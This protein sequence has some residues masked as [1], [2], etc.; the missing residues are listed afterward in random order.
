MGNR[1]LREA[2][3]RVS[4][5]SMEKSRAIK[6]AISKGKL[7]ISAAS[8]EAGS[9]VEE[10]DAA[11]DDV[12]LEIGFNARYILDMTDQVEGKEITFM[13]SDTASP[14]LVQDAADDSGVFVI[15][16]MRV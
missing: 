13:L 7:V 6:L 10:L 12:P 15:M 11:Y 1:E 8:P 14:T 9:G 3:D 5:I 2:V 16:P 4:T